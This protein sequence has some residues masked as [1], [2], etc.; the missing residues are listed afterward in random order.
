MEKKDLNIIATA[1]HINDFVKKHNV[2][3]IEEAFSSKDTAI[4][5]SFSNFGK[6]RDKG[7]LLFLVQQTKSCNQEMEV[8]KAIKRL[9]CLLNPDKK[10]S[11]RENLDQMVDI[12]TQLRGIND[13][14]TEQE[15][16]LSDEYLALSKAIYIFSK[17]MTIS[18][19]KGIK[20]VNDSYLIK[21]MLSPDDQTNMSNLL[22][23]ANQLAQK[24]KEIVISMKLPL[25]PA[26]RARGNETISWKNFL[27]NYRAITP[28][29]CPELF[30]IPTVCGGLIYTASGNFFN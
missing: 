10:K 6:S 19:E 26:E 21:K 12:G 24:S 7:M 25:P 28:F 30:P 23:L 16:S 8:V 2:A 1:N 15:S 27:R 17:N 18:L 5:R 11:L 20:K 4:Y 9:D 3:E 14:L 22:K 29:S 13:W